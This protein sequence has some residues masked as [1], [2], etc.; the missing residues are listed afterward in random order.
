MTVVKETGA[1]IASITRALQRLVRERG[2]PEERLEL[3][4][5]VE[6]TVG[7]A[8]LLGA[9]RDIALELRA[10]GDADVVARPADL[11]S[12]VLGALLDGLDASEPRARLDVVV[13]GRTVS[14]SAG[15]ETNALLGPAA[16]ALG[17]VVER[18]AAGGVTLR[19]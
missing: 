5:F 7:L 11:R 2:Q 13:S 8:R 17:V 19:F 4:S 18:D 10:D 1:E 16:A 9:V 14:V 12:V 3:D 6:E 15:S